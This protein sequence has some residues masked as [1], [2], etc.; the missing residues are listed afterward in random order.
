[1][2]RLGYACINMT[3]KDKC[4][5]RT[6][7]LKTFEEKGLAYVSELALQNVLDLKDVIQWNE[8]NGINFFR[9]S[10]D[11]FPW[12]CRYDLE[13]LP[14]FQAIQQTLTEIGLMVKKYDHRITMH[15]GP[16]NVLASP[17]ANVIQRTVRELTDHAVVMDLLGLSY[18]P[19]NKIN[20]HV[21]GAY[22]DKDNAL[23]TWCRNFELL[24]DN[25]KCRL[26]I[27]NDDKANAFNV[28]DLMTIHNRVGIPIVFDYHHHTFNTGGLTHKEAFEIAYDTWDGIVPAFHI[29]EPRDEVKPRSHHDFIVNKVD[30]FGKD[31]DLMFECKQKD[32]ALLKY[33]QMYNL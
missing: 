8:D 11:V 7:R 14:D 32:I 28:L 12:Q 19:Y 4:T 22:G 9:M 1:M 27:E 18:T 16:F 20:I 6:M 21:G 24:P 31:V 29:S 2:S 17:N 26:T 25:V 5:S 15:P 30:T 3:L 13:D 23:D 33:K 10:S